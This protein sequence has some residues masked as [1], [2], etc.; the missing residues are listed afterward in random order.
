MELF[1]PKT[2]V[3]RC[4]KLLH[5]QTS[6]AAAQPFFIP[7]DDKL[8]SELNAPRFK[9]WFRSHWARLVVKG[10]IENSPGGVTV[11]YRSRLLLIFYIFY[12][13]MFVISLSAGH[14]TAPLFVLI[15]ITLFSKFLHFI[16]KPYVRQIE[17]LF[18][19]MQGG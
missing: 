12:L 1:I 10:T 6:P 17:D 11:R 8:V 14:F 18:K 5:E 13:G 7:L 16:N 4:F 19:S 2:N 15:M 3:D 9:L